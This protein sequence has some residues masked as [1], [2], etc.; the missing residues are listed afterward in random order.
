[1]LEREYWCTHGAE[2]RNWGTLQ[3]GIDIWSFIQTSTIKH[4][5]Y[6]LYSALDGFSRVNKELGRDIGDRILKQVWDNLLETVPKGAFAIRKSG[7]TFLLLMNVPESVL[8]Q[9]VLKHIQPFYVS[10]FGFLYRS[11]GCVR[12]YPAPNSVDDWL[13]ISMESDIALSE[14]KNRGGNLTVFND[15][16]DGFKIL[17]CGPEASR[18]AV[19]DFE[20]SKYCG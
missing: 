12:I 17:A 7:D 6:L 15:K 8:K 2:L 4:E 10:E 13:Q 3:K 1:M 16:T 14:A 19:T 20:R 5:G 18:K 9:F 11:V